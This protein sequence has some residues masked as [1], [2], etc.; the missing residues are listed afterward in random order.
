MNYLQRGSS[1]YIVATRITAEHTT[2]REDLRPH[3]CAMI[4]MA[5]TN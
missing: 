1:D 2:Y 3:G 5:E 4:D